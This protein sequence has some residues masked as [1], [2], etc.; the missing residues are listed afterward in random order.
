VVVAFCRA[1]HL[2]R[3]PCRRSGAPWTPSDARARGLPL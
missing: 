3:R 2:G 1:L